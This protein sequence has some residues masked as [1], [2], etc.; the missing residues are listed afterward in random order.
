MKNELRRSDRSGGFFPSFFDYFLNDNLVERS[1]PA[2]NISENDKEFRVELSVPGYA[3]DDVAIELDHNVLKVSA[4]IETRNEEKDETQKVLR[5]EFKS[6]SFTRSFVLPENV[7]VSNISAS[8]NDGV[9][10][11][12]LPK[13]QFSAG[14][15]VKK[16]EIR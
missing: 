9:L 6:S 14:D 4:R 15:R 2:T 11:V 5:Q 13:L 8:Q 1:I 10:V 7:D 16:I 3:K 12:S